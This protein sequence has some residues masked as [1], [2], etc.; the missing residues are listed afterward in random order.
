MAGSQVQVRNRIPQF[1]L[2]HRMALAL[3]KARVSRN[4]IARIVGVH[5]NTIGNYLTGRTDPPRSVLIAWA[6]RCDVPLEWLIEGDDDPDP[7]TIWYRDMAC[8]AAAIAA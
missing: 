1:E 6:L 2:R 3:E 7:S 4:E 5:L 8:M